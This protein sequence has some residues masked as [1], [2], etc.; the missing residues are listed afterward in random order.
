MQI[1]NAFNLNVFT[2]I[3][4]NP[5]SSLELSFPGHAEMFHAT[6]SRKVA[7][8]NKATRSMLADKFHSAPL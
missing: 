2:R 4:S 1:D 8:T 3:P 6:T 7:T 5:E